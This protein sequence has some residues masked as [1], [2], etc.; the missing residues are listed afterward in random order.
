MSPNRNYFATY[1]HIYGGNIVM[2]NEVVCKVVGIW[3]I[4]MR[5]HDGSFCL[6]N[7]VRHVSQMTKNLISISLLDIKGFSFK[8]KCVVAYVCK[9]PRKILKGMKHDSFYALQMFV[10][11]GSAIVT[12]SEVHKEDMIT[13]WHMRLDHKGEL[14]M[15]ILSKR[16]LLYVHKV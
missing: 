8:E 3:S 15:K 2:A 9:G 7:K 16:D 14:G 1:E 4:K 13:L 12:S 10:L 5:T 6:V 11:S